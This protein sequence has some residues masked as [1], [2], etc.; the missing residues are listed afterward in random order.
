MSTS[1]SLRLVTVCG[2]YSLEATPQEIV[3]AFALAEAIALSPR[4]NIAPT[5]GVPIVR[6]DPETGG[7]ARYS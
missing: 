1:Y 3:E 4:Y 6:L 2:R 7:G 5:Q